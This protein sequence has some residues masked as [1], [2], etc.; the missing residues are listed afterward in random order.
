M[1]QPS[2]DNTLIKLLDVNKDVRPGLS[3]TNSVEKSFTCCEEVSNCNDTELATEKWVLRMSKDSGKTGALIQ[4]MLNEA[5]Y[6][7][8]GESNLCIIQVKTPSIQECSGGFKTQ[9]PSYQRGYP[10]KINRGLIATIKQKFIATKALYDQFE[11]NFRKYIE[12][13]FSVGSSGFI[14]LN[15]RLETSRFE[16]LDYVKKDLL[17]TDERRR[18]S[19]KVAG[20]ERNYLFP[21]IFNLINS[22]CK[23]KLPYWGVTSKLKLSNKPGYNIFTEAV[24]NVKDLIKATVEAL[25]AKIKMVLQIKLRKLQKQLIKQLIGIFQIDRRY[26]L[27]TIVRSMCVFTSDGKDV[28]NVIALT[29]TE[30]VTSL[31]HLLKS[32]ECLIVDRY[33][34]WLKT[35][36][37]LWKE[38]T[39]YVLMI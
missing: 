34:K 8:I 14:F 12:D 35:P 10:K 15:T 11:Y 5:D 4:D 31:F 19:H 1:S 9:L 2:I 6:V 30:K 13:V 23:H 24:P 27:R 21:Q 28:D 39:S 22:S 37:L 29:N 17:H 36:L 26:L 18:L 25:L 32:S 20:N 33:C 7:A 38:K 3:V 16:D